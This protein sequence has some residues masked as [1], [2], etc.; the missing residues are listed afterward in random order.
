ME[1]PFKAFLGGFDKGIDL[2][3]NTMGYFYNEHF[4]IFDGKLGSDV[5]F[6]GKRRKKRLFA[7]RS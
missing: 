2:A 5:F 6:L 1:K 3:S 4:E 7:Q